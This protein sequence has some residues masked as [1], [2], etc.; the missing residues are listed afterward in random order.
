MKTLIIQKCIIKF[1]ITFIISFLW[2]RFV[3]ISPLLTIAEYPLIFFGAL[4]LALAWF[5]Y[6][7]LDG[8]RFTP[9]PKEKKKSNTKKHKSKQMIDYVDTELQGEIELTPKQVVQSK[10]ISNLICGVILILPSVY[11]FFTR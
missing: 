5:N 8:F 3:R 1:L 10:L 4:F 11:L 7:K 2:A 9:M 6:L